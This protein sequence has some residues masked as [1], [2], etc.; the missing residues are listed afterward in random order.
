MAHPP[1]APPPPPPPP[2][3]E[4]PWWAALLLEREPEWWEVEPTQLDLD[5][6]LLLAPMEVQ[7]EVAAPTLW[8]NPPPPPP[9]HQ[10]RMIPLTAAPAA[11]A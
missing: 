5:L 9:H 3:E 7:Q 11:L 10:M 1:L 4:E 6:D 8:P 2:E